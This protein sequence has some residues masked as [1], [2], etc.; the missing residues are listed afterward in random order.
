MILMFVS[1]T[2]KVCLPLTTA[3]DQRR[4][5]SHSNTLD[6]PVLAYRLDLGYSVDKDIDVEDSLDSAHTPGALEEAVDTSELLLLSVCFEQCSCFEQS[7]SY[8]DAQ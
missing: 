1:I 4:C 2:T 8:F 3:Y 5:F 6:A 7:P